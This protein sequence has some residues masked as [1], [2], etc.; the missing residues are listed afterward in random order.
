MD[1]SYCV[2]SLFVF[3]SCFKIFVDSWQKEIP[4]IISLSLA[5][6]IFKDFLRIHRGFII[7][8]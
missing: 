1:F 5:K 4:R 6:I 2:V 3:L 7:K 8:L